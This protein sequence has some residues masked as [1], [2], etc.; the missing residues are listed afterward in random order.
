M[1]ELNVRVLKW[2][3]AGK[4]EVQLKEIKDTFEI[5]DKLARELIKNLEFKKV[6]GPFIPMRGNCFLNR[7]YVNL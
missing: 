7:K 5:S 4:N 6:L 3:A 1:R 2:L